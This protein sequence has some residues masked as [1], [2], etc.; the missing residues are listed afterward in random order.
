MEVSPDELRGLGQ[1]GDHLSLDLECALA[2][3]ALEK[4]PQSRSQIVRCH[5][6]WSGRKV[7]V[8]R[9]LATPM[10]AEAAG[11]QLKIYDREVVATDCEPPP[12]GPRAQVVRGSCRRGEASHLQHIFD[13]RPQDLVDAF[14]V[15]QG[16]GARWLTFHGRCSLSMR[17]G[18]CLPVLVTTGDSRANRA[19][20]NSWS[21]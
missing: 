12:A 11:I 8:Q 3:T 17:Q 2:M 19:E 6:C 21:M 14:R 18:Y 20:P 13:C 16:K 10:P 1:R 4:L 9:E 15:D 5:R 7:E